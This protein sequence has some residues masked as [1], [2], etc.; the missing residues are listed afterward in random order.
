MQ[1]QEGCGTEQ[2]QRTLAGIRVIGCRLM[3]GMGLS[4]FMRLFGD[5][6]SLQD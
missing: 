5:L 6:R 3:G 2:K 4:V 1:K